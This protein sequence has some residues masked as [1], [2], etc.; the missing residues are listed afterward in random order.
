MVLRPRYVPP[1]DDKEPEKVHCARHAAKQDKRWAELEQELAEAAGRLQEV[2]AVVLSG[3]PFGSLQKGEEEEDEETLTRDARHELR[4]SN[5][6]SERAKHLRSR[7][8]DASN[9]LQD[10][11][12]RRLRKKVLDVLAEVSRRQLLERQQE[13][14]KRFWE[15]RQKAGLAPRGSLGD[16]SELALGLRP[17]AAETLRAALTTSPRRTC[18]LD[19][20][21][22]EEMD[23]IRKNVRFFFEDGPQS[24]RS[25]AG[26]EHREDSRSE[27]GE[28]AELV[29]FFTPSKQ[30]KDLPVAAYVRKL[31]LRLEE[32][33][34]EAGG[35]SLYHSQ[36]EFRLPRWAGGLIPEGPRARSASP[37]QPPE[38][39]YERMP[40][41]GRRPAVR[42]DAESPTLMK[43]K[44]V[45][46]KKDEADAKWLSERK[47]AMAEREAANAFKSQEQQRA[48]EAR[49]T[50]HKELHKVR[51]MET[52]ERKLLMDAAS[53]TKRQT[54][55]VVKTRKLEVASELA[56]EMTE[57]KRDKATET[58]EDWRRGVM[59]S[60]RHFQ[61]KEQQLQHE[62]QLGMERYLEK[63]ARVGSLKHTVLES[64]AAKNDRLKTRIQGSLVD[65]LRAEQRERGAKLSEELE[66]KMEA[67]A[68]RRKQLQF[69]AKY[70]F[71]EK[72]LGEQAVGFDVKYD[73]TVVDMR[74]KLWQKNLEAWSKQMKGDTQTTLTSG[75]SLLA[76]L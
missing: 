11:A 16:A 23:L 4:L 2:K 65:L 33:V 58:L 53:L 47:R 34:E 20:L 69:G 30:D 19:S 54:D 42:H 64:H 39:A 74:K 76:T 46:H 27:A 1:P 28:E 49:T 37:E 44:E 36:S 10:H 68:L 15:E 45:F 75:K 51:M 21:S 12:K 14:S 66:S 50:Q 62:G 25:P 24:P 67:A 6:F 31:R 57:R 29:S 35:G 52:E 26:S 9:K 60:A 7:A 22:L 5:A 71:L 17:A 63:L 40:C 59:R 70:C 3:K 41:L 32:E 61:Q 73:P 72:S 56:E 55:A 48:L 13:K 43:V 38:A 8:S 18:L